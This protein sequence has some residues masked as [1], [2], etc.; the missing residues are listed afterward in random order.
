MVPAAIFATD[1]PLGPDSRRQPGV[2]EGKLEKHTWTSAIFPGTVRDYWV[3]VP[4][5]Y[6]GSRA[7]RGDGLPGRRLDVRDRRG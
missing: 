5:Q 2:P 4:A 1:Y 3:Y 6:D 7:R